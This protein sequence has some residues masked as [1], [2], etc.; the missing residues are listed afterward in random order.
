MGLVI[1][2]YQP[3]PSKRQNQHGIHLIIEC[4][5]GVCWAKAQSQCPALYCKYTHGRSNLQS[6]CRFA[7]ET[8][9]GVRTAGRPGSGTPLCSVA[10]WKGFRFLAWT[11]LARTLASPR[12]ASRY[13]LISLAVCAPVS[14]ATAFHTAK[15]CL[16]K[17]SRIDSE[18]SA[19]H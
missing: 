9:H 7:D 1:K 14:S 17:W 16:Q 6:R 3:P 18:K 8:P 5:T 15:P 12:L 13:G 4:W 2:T 19:T 11:C 10:P